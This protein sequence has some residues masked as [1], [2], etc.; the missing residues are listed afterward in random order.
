MAQTL[1]IDRIL[2]NLGYCTRKEAKARAKDGRILNKGVLV[3][4]V[5]EHANPHDITVDGEPLD[6]PDGIYIA[7]NKPAGLV[8]SH[9]TRDG[10]NVYSLL[11]WQWLMRNPMVSSV[12]RLDKDTTGLLL[13]TDDTE[14]IHRMISP[15]HHVQKVYLVELDKHPDDSLIA[16]F[17]SGTIILEKETKPCRPAGL[18]II[19]DKQCEVTLLEGKYHQIKRMFEAFGYTVTKLHRQTFGNVSVD[20]IAEGEYMEFDP[21]SI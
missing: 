11:P 7:L 6:H 9:E 13:I 8:C 12:G 15:I 17:A 19:G 16:Q 10:T 2:S 4:D 3:S 18:K 5:S 14:F 21:K 20:E 1:R